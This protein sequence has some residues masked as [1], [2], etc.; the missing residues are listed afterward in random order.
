MQFVGLT[1]GR[2]AAYR[3]LATNLL[4]CSALEI[5]YLMFLCR[6]WDILEEC[7]MRLSEIEAFFLPHRVILFCVASTK[8]LG[9]VVCG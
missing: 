7:P 4:L 9:P 5:Q 6:N 3:M 8:D 2:C 1:E